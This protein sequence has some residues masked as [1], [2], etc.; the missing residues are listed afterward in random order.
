MFYQPAA[1][2][3]AGMTNAASL[4]LYDVLYCYSLIPLCPTY[5]YALY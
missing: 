3:F 2:A 1:S 4:T 5:P